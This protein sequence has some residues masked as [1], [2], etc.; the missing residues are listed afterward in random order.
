MLTPAVAAALVLAALDDVKTVDVTCPLDGHRFQAQ[1]VV[2]H[3][4]ARAWGGLDRDFC[5]H[6]FKTAPLQAAAWACPACGF[7]GG[8]ADFDAKVALSDDDK[9]RILGHLAPAVP[10]RKG[11]KQ[12]AI[13]GHAKFDLAAQ[14]AV[15]KGAPAI[16]VAR[17]Y[18]AAS[19]C[20]RQEGAVQ[21]AGYDAWLDLRKRYNLDIPPLEL[22]SRNRTDFELDVAAR[23]EKSIEGR[24]A[25]EARDRATVEECDRDAG[26]ER[27]RG[28]A[29]GRL[30]EVNLLKYGAMYLYRRH[31]ENVE[32]L[33][34]IEELA[35][36]KG[37]N[38]VVDDAVRRTAES[39][40][41]ERAYQRKAVEW[42]EKTLSDAAPEKGA[43]AQ[44]RYLLGELARRL[45][46]RAKAAQWYRGAL[47]DPAVGKLAREQLKRVE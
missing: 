23:I 22:G 31:G 47:E 34:W 4:F 46:D 37:D 5:R 26:D 41:L 40:E 28:E 13:P 18:L 14:V 32:A 3:D 16:E 19:W 24:R 6:A 10:I 12:D 11:M 9:R 17:A 38:S 29:R 20:A 1:E 27:R 8:K 42:A 35:K 33:R 45:G 44:C 21:P 43:Q 25:Q 2:S 39:I 15:L 30:H 7:A 36:A